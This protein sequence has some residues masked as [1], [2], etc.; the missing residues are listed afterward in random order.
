MCYKCPFAWLRTMHDDVW[1]SGGIAPCSLELLEVSGK[2]HSPAALPP[3][4]EVPVW[5]PQPVWASWRKHFL[6]YHL[7]QKCWFLFPASTANCF[8]N[9]K[10]TKFTGEWNS[11]SEFYILTALWDNC[12]AIIRLSESI[13]AVRNSIIFLD[14]FSHYGGKC[15]PWSYRIRAWL[16]T[17][18]QSADNR[19]SYTLYE[20]NQ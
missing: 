5:V 7:V 1:V 3:Q 2:L 6:P 19:E 15:S 12:L 16:V 17:S 10:I 20:C 9:F 8:I 18:A 14:W 4:K 13:Y 11:E